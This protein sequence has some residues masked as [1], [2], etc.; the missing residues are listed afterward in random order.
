MKPGMLVSA[1]AILHA[2]ACATSAVSFVADGVEYSRR[3]CLGDSTLVEAQREWRCV[4][5]SG[6]LNGPVMQWIDDDIVVYT[7]YLHGSRSGRYLQ[8]RSDGTLFARGEFKDGLPSGKWEVFHGNGRLR[9]E[10]RFDAGKRVGVWTLVDRS[11]SL[12]TVDVERA[13][14]G[15]PDEVCPIP[16][17]SQPS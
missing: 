8:W 12:R 4:D 1:Y 11:G 2:A 14:I 13:T 9:C 6:A 5:A 7:E 3:T 10:G 17:P 16:D 15:G